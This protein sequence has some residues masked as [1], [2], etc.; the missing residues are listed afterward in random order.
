M[1]TAAFTYENEAT[2]EPLNLS[3]HELHRST[4][5]FNIF[6]LFIGKKQE[7]KQ[8]LGLKRSASLRQ[9]KACSRERDPPRPETSIDDLKLSIA[10]RTSHRFT[11]AVRILR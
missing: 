1:K 2:F 5:Q 8:E 11:Q 6:G 3:N 4:L 10:S 9:H 7:L